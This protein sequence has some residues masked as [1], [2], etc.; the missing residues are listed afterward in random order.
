MKKDEKISLWKTRIEDRKN[1]G[2]NV[3][4]WCAENNV[5]RHAY[6]YWHRKIT[7]LETTVE[8]AV[9]AEVFPQKETVP[10]EE[11]LEGINIK[12]K[13]FSITIK[14]KHAVPLMAELM[15]SLE[16]LC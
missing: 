7:L 5:S 15:T 13:D 16:T 8:T 4:D 14:D 6:Y 11:K 9:F 3:A 12:W 10:V 1:S 2:Q